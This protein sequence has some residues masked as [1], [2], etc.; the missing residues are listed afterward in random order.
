MRSLLDVRL[1][2]VVAMLALAPAGCGRNSDS[3]VDETQ[4]TSA[5][6]VAATASAPTPNQSACLPESPPISTPAHP[7]YAE[8]Q[9]LQSTESPYDR[10][11]ANES[12]S[13]PRY[14]DISDVGVPY[15]IPNDPLAAQV[16]R[17]RSAAP[18]PAQEPFPETSFGPSAAPSGFPETSFGPN[19]EQPELPMRLPPQ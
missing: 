15:P 10:P 17:I 2:F 9:L 16:P 4:T 12:N 7:T 3:R 8:V 1:T 11:L 5:V 13:S 19:H 6:V 18:V 14:S